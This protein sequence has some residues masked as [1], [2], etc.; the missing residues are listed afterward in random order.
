MYQEMIGSSKT[1][2]LN[3]GKLRAALGR[4]GPWRQ[5]GVREYHDE[6]LYDLAT[7]KRRNIRLN[8]L[9]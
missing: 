4:R 9:R 8:R 5:C 6:L 3:I 7:A 1:L 2:S